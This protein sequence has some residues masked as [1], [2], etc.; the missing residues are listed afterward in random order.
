MKPPPR[1]LFPRVLVC[2]RLSLAALNFYHLILNPVVLRGAVPRESHVAAVSD[3]VRTLPLAL[4]P[5][6]DHIREASFDL[7]LELLGHR[8]LR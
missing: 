7:I 4:I 8:L 6:A 1:E 3:T 2:H 5:D